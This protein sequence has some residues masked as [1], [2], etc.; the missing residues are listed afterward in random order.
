MKK[1]ILPFLFVAT[2]ASAQFS[3]P[4]YL[5][6][7]CQS[8][9]PSIVDGVSDGKVVGILNV[10]V[11]LPLGTSQIDLGM[12]LD[13]GK[14][15]VWLYLVH[16]TATD[17]MYTVPITRALGSCSKLP[18]D[19]PSEDLGDDMELPLI[20]VPNQFLQGTDLM[21]KLKSN[22]QFQQFQASYPDSLPR[23]VVLGTTEEEVLG[24]PENTPA[25]VF[26]WPSENE[27]FGFMC[28]VNA[29][30]GETV[31]IGNTVDNVT[32]NTPQ[33]SN[34]TAFPNPTNDVAYLQVPIDWITQPLVVDAVNPAG[35]S[36]RVFD[37]RF[38]MLPVQ[39][40]TSQLLAGL[41]TL[42]ARTTSETR[43]T[44]IVVSK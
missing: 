16:S 34:L 24:F 28:V 37:S 43:V 3:F 35:Q 29:S 11:S 17:S 12:S 14:A 44:R 41:W 25:W 6:G 13:D 31:C 22:Q 1:L 21:G 40:Q 23:I 39:I 18:I 10:R 36:V 19:V 26:S 32:E 30:S 2:L 27:E 7:D 5:P 4:G 8:A 9:A 20:P 15:P 38:T 42:V 33:V